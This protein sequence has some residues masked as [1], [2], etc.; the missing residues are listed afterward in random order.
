MALQSLLDGT[1]PKIIKGATSLNHILQVT[2]CFWLRN[3]LN[4]ILFV[5]LFTKEQFGREISYYWRNEWNKGYAQFLMQPVWVMLLPPQLSGR[6]PAS[7][8]APARRSEDVA[9]RVAQ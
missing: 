5:A 4:N 8:V 2:N 1:A 9:Q 6:L 3:L 7:V